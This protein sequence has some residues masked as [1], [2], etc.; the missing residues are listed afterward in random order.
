MK[1]YRAFADD[2]ETHEVVFGESASKARSAAFGLYGLDD[3][4][5]IFI[6][7]ERL[8]LFDKFYTGKSSV[9]NANNLEAQRVMR[10]EGWW[11]SENFSS[12]GD[13]GLYE[14]DDLEESHLDDNDQC[15]ECRNE[16]A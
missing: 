3:A 16:C 1:A 2:V 13:C 12:C 7:V 5:F 9:L 15:V 8:P 6:K 14:F 11:M 4:E 10:N